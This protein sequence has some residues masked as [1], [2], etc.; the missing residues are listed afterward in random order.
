MNR[1]NETTLPQLA[2]DVQ[3]PG[4]DRSLISAGIVHFGAGNFHRA[5]QA[6]YCDTLLNQGENSWGI[7]GVSLRSP[8]V[9]DSLVP[10]DCL[11]TQAT[12]G[13]TTSY[14]VIAAIKGLLVAPENPQAVIDAVAGD[15]TQL[16]TTTITEKGYCLA[17]GAIDRNHPDLSRDLHSLSAPQTTYGYLAA[18]LIKRCAAQGKPLTVL[19]CDNMHG[20]GEHL[21][22]G[23]RLLLEVHSPDT[24]AWVSR[25]CV[26]SSSMVDRVTPATDTALKEKVAERLGVYDAAPVA[27]EPFS[28]WVIEDRFAGERSP[29]DRAGALFVESIGPYEQVK[30]RFLNAGH[31]MLAALGYLA[32]DRFIHEA[33]QR[34]PLARFTEQALK[35]CVLPVTAV[36]ADVDGV[37]Y[38]NQVLGRFRNANLP[39]AVLQVGSDSSQKIQQRWLPS[40]DDALSRERDAAYLAFALAAWASFI[41]KA[42]ANDDLNDPLRNDFARCESA[43]PRSPVRDYLAL[44][45]AA[46]FAFVNNETFM[47]SVDGF[48]HTIAEQGVEQALVNFL[49][50]VN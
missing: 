17:N 16:V 9:R 38:I 28:Q 41:R 46:K 43:A 4:Y 24:W 45:G 26:F 22:A 31:S 30:L 25:N 40:I 29:F 15:R 14:R 27:A 3:L 42:L 32:G 19:C 23:V 11:Y 12:L 39:Y 20:G 18:A 21:A 48:Y 2:S 13:E 44:A 8:A 49:T 47:E 1:L 10:Q 35:Q 6:V 7:I 36:P 50:S 33:L 5:H 37:D 34:E